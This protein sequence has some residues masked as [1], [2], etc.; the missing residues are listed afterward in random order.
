M[1][2]LLAMVVTSV[3]ASHIGL[4]TSSAI[5]SASSSASCFS[6]SRKRVQT[7]MRSASGVKAQ[8]S[9]ASRAAAA[10]WPTSCAVDS[11]L[12]Q[13]CLPFD[14]SMVTSSAPLPASH[15]PLMKLLNTLLK[16]LDMG[17]L[18]QIKGQRAHRIAGMAVQELLFGFR[19]RDGAVDRH[20][21]RQDHA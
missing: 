6:R 1:S 20:R 12:A 11:L 9:N 10:A 17:I 15:S 3:R 5:S 14:G 4:P 18:P 13:V 7:A 21:L 19:Q 2:I 8:A 16:A